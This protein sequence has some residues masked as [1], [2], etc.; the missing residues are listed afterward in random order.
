MKH[1]YYKIVCFLAL[2]VSVL[3]DLS[4]EQIEKMVKQI[5]LKRPGISLEKLEHTKEP[6]VRL[7]REENGENNT[8]VEVVF[9]NSEETQNV[10]FTLHGLMNGKA[11]I[12]DGWK[13]KGDSVLGYTIEHIG[14]KGVVL[15]R[16]DRIV[17]LFLPRKKE[18]NIITLK[19]KE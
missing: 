8:S 10:K 11:Y 4:V 13:K 9:A 17:T 19:E 3:A 7:Q 6:F 15:R 1:L 14:K 2:S 5:H 18:N 16:N 12:N